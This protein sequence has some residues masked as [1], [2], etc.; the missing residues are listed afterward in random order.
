MNYS[1]IVACD[2]SGGIGNNG[3][4]PWPSIQEDTVRF[5]K[6]TTITQ[7]PKKRNA[8]IMGR[9]T[10]DSIP[11]E[12]KP[13][14]DRLNIILSLNPYQKNKIKKKYDK[15]DVIVFNEVYKAL[16]HVGYERDIE[17]IFIIGGEQIYKKA[18]QTNTYD[19]ID[20][21][22]DKMYLTYIDDDF[23]SDCFMPT[24]PNWMF[25]IKE[26]K[27]MSEIGIP[28][29]FKLYK[30]QKNNWYGKGGIHR[31][32][33]QYIELVKDIL[34]HGQTQN[35]RNGVT[36]SIFGPQHEF[37]LSYGFP[38]LTTKQ[39]PFKTIVKELLF[40][41]NGS[42][43]ANILK[44]QGVGI[45]DANTSKQFLKSRGLD[46]E[47][48][49]MGPM[50]GFNWRH[51]GAIYKG[52]KTDYDGQGYDQ[53]YNLI[54]K[55]VKE[56]TSRRHL[57]TTY[58]PSTVDQSVLAPCHGLTIQFNARSVANDIILDCKMYQRSVDVAL[59]YPFNI[60]S[61]ALFVHLVCYVTGYKPGKLIMSL[62]NAH[63]YKEHI[64]IIKPQLLRRPL[65]LPT[66]KIIKEFDSKN[67]TTC[68]RIKFL[69]N[70]TCADIKLIDYYS[71]PAIKMNM[72]A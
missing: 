12:N 72:I 23:K 32:E 66:L 62:G 63:I 61:Y 10:W 6:I 43:N 1:I 7:D 67:A 55:L 5:Y 49:D 44:E 50:Y 8:V 57:M 53:L 58:D 21:Y 68:N 36:K 13:L 71:Y 39:M 37:D 15:K 16:R 19:A 26:E 51:F 30:N 60:T 46:Y 70:I 47:P 18:F 52:C 33:G 65:F 38:I 24:I 35:G 31:T 17:N 11:D 14:S 4:L 64:K 20:E 28:L 59:G 40:F 48:G 25:L 41:I 54:D 22:V 45:W 9:K 42:T 27:I 2:K 29:N 56:P 69:E 34:N 3:D